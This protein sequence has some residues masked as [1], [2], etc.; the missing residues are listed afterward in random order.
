MISL[1]KLAGAN[2]LQ[3]VKAQPLLV[4]AFPTT[5]AMFFYECRAIVG[6]NTVGKALVTT[7]SCTSNEGFGNNVELLRQQGSSKSVWDTYNP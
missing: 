4:V 3:I 2:G 5:G 1:A 6:N 7:Y